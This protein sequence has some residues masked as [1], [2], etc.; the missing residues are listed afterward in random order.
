[1]NPRTLDILATT[2]ADMWQRGEVSTSAEQMVW[3]AFLREIRKP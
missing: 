2:L 3:R 1:M